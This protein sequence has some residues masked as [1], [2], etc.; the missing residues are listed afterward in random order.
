VKR[1][2]RHQAVRLQIYLFF[3]SQVTGRLLRQFTNF[4]QRQLPVASG[5]ATA[6]FA[7]AKT[8]KTSAAAVSA[9]KAPTAKTSAEAAA[10]EHTEKQTKE[11]TGTEEDED[12]KND[13][14]ADN[15]AK[16]GDGMAADR[17]QF[18][19]WIWIRV[20]QRSSSV[21][22]DDLSNLDKTRGDSAVVVA[23]LES[24]DHD[25]ANIAD[26]AVGENAFQSVSDFNP[27]LVVV[28]RKQHEHTTVR[29][30]SANLPLFFQSIGKVGL[31]VSIKIVDGDDGYLGVAFA[32]V[33]L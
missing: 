23:S 17:S 20:G 9:A 12:G 18:L 25:S 4:R 11:A 26:L 24:G 13:D 29:S 6:G 5:S 33:E 27:V 8:S 10:H 2:G 22:S 30:L 32:M 1:L 19:V 15:Q 31:V 21:G 16:R 28:N 3:E 14:N 7:A